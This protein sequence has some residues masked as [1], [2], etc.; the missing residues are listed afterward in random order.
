[1]NLQLL[2]PE[3]GWTVPALANWLDRQIPHRDIPQA[4]SSLFIANVLTGLTQAR[5]VTVEQLARQKYRLRNAI[6]AK[7][8]LHRKAQA[9]Q[10]FDRLLFD[11]ASPN[12]EVSPEICFQYD[13]NRY[14]PSNYYDGPLPFRKHYF[15][16]VGELE[17][18]GEQFECATVI[19]GLPQVKF[20]VRNL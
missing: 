12:I 10:S 13:E 2:Y 9:K 16:R 5:N 7:I 6:A 19:D 1:M 14:A 11:V 20:W 15:P 18:E 4:Q 8:D 3:P 17:G